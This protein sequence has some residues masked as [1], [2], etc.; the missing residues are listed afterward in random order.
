LAPFIADLGRDIDDWLY[1][2]VSNKLENRAIFT[3]ADQLHFENIGFLPP[4][5]FMGHRDY[6]QIM[7]ILAEKYDRLRDIINW[8]EADALKPRVFCT[9]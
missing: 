8:S 4:N 6:A 1:E 7:R 5:D 9:S 3:R 2:R